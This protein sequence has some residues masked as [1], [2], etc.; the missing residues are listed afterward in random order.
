MVKMPG[1][2]KFHAVKQRFKMKRR[3]YKRRA[4]TAAT[5]I[6]AMFRR[7]RDRGRFHRA[8][9]RKAV[10]KFNRQSG[11]MVYKS[12]TIVCPDAMLVTPGTGTLAGSGIS[13]VD[14]VTGHYSNVFELGMTIKDPSQPNGTKFFSKELAQYCGLFKQAKIVH[15]S[16]S[17]LRYNQGAN[18]G[19]P[20]TGTPPTSSIGTT[21]S[22]N[23]ICYVHSV[24][25]SGAFKSAVE[26]Q[27]LSVPPL[28]NIASTDADVYLANS[29]S[30]FRQLSWDTKK[31][32]KTK[33]ICPTSKEEWAQQR[34]PIFDNSTP[35]VP[36][37]AL[38]TNCPWLDT[39]TLLGVWNN[40]Y[41][42]GNGNYESIYAL[43]RLPTLSVFG[44]NFP[45]AVVTAANLPRAVQY[46]IHKVLISIT[47]AF[48]IPTT[49]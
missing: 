17:M 10:V 7:R 36:G 18:D 26:L 22:K 23:W 44:S 15:G 21:G 28:T 20:S 45:I 11:E 1:K 25:D 41:A 13:C 27:K 32:L 42:A 46:P 47:C 43:G 9:K 30:R 31:S 3:R 19:N 38:R 2:R 49:T 4:G 48:R 16:V 37:I 24:I 39:D 6:Q 5:K 8:L 14:P 34:Y 12:F 33:V 35:P 29:N 40:G